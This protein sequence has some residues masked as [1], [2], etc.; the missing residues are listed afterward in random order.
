MYKQIQLP[1]LDKKQY[2]VS[3]ALTNVN[4]IFALLMIANN[5]KIIHI[6]HSERFSC[7]V[8]TAVFVFDQ[9]LLHFLGTRR[10]YT[11]SRHFKHIFICT[12]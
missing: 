3:Y 7:C 9:C 5:T 1:P 8:S 6:I 4:L 2:Y 12:S 11:S 10:L